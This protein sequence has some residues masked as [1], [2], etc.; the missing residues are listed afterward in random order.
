MPLGDTDENPRGIGLLALMAEDLK[1]HDGSLRE[2]GFWALV[3]HRL[4]NARMQVRSKALRAPLTLA[5]RIM[6]T[7]V[8]Y[9]WGIDLQYNVKLGRRV[10][11]RHRGTLLLG[12]RAIG[13]DVEIGH[14]VTFGVA[15]RRLPS[16]KP[17]IGN[18]V[19]IGPG[20]CILG[21]VTVGDDCTIGPNSVVVRDLPAGSSALGVPAKPVNMSPAELGRLK[22]EGSG[23]I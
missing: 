16:H 18:R 23:R 11:I 2:P 15:D 12:A 5:Y 6:F 7:G 3:V 20:A 22:R 14:N 13:D 19:S 17:I 21:A 8:T 10:R 9:R 1:T 4:G